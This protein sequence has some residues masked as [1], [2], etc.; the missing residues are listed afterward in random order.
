MT[1][2]MNLRKIIRVGYPDGPWEEI[3]LGPEVNKG[4]V[5]GLD[6]YMVYPLR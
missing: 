6:G 2:K 1:M 3:I 4:Q 5:I